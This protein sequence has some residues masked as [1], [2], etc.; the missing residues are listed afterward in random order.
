MWGL[1]FGVLGPQWYPF[2]LFLWFKDS[3]LQSSQPQKGYPSRNMVT[4]LTRFGV[5]DLGLGCWLE[6]FKFFGFRF[7]GKA[8][9]FP[10]IAVL[11]SC[12]GLRPTMHMSAECPV[13]RCSPAWVLASKPSSSSADGAPRRSSAA[14]RRSSTIHRDAKRRV[15]NLI[16]K[17]ESLNPATNVVHRPGVPEI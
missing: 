5:R 16:N 9:G 6:A 12:I 4:D 10:W 1:G 2:S 14:C 13:H 7:G 3:L 17:C 11:G 15:T 8:E